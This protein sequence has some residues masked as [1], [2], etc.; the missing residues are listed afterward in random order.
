[1]KLSRFSFH[2]D[3][4][5]YQLVTLVNELL[6]ASVEHKPERHRRLF[7]THL[8]PRGIKELAAPRQQRI[9]LAVVRLLDSLEV[10]G[11]RERLA[12]LRALRDELLLGSSAHMR[13][14]TARVLIAIMKRLVRERGNLPAQLLLAHDFFRAVSGQPRVIRRELCRH[15]LLE[16]P[17]QWSQIA[18]DH[19]VHDANTKGRKAPTHLIMD[20]CVKG[21]RELM[22]VYYNYMR[23]DAVAE[24]TEAAEIMGIEVRAGVE[25]S[26]RF[27]GKYVQLIWFPHGF[28]GHR[29]L[30]DFLGQ[31]RVEAFFEEGK[32]VAALSRRHVLALLASFNQNHLSSLNSKYSLELAPLDEEEFLAFVGIGQPSVVHLA[33]FIHHLVLPR[34]PKK[35]RE[36][37]KRLASA[38]EQK[39]ARIRIA[40]ELLNDLIPERITEEYLRPIDNVDVP[41][42]M[43]PVPGEPLP[44]LLSL[45]L[46]EIVER[47]NSIRSGY[48]LV[49]NP[50]NLSAADVLEL[51]Y[52]AEG[53]ITGLEIFN[54]KDYVQGTNSHIPTIARLRH[55]INAGGAIACKRLV[56]A[57]LRDVSE[58][59]DPDKG[60]RCEKLQRILHDLPRLLSF[61]D[62]NPIRARM[63]SDSTGRARSLFG[64]GLAVEKTLPGA[65]R[66]EIKRRPGLRETIPVRM[67]AVLQRTWFPRRGHTESQV[68]FY[69]ALRRLPLLRT[70]GYEPQSQYVHLENQTRYVE[71]G[72]IVTLGGV[73]VEAD[74]NLHLHAKDEPDSAVTAGTRHL[75]V[76]WR[77]ALK[78][79][80]G[81]V[82]AF[83]T[84]YLTQS[85]WVLAY[86]GAFIWF[87]VT[88]LRNVVQSVVGGGGLLR[89]Q[90][91]KWNDLVR[92]ERVC[93]DLLF[94]GFSVPLLD[95]LVK[96]VILDHGFGVTTMTA[97]VVLYSIMGLANGIYL[98]SHNTFRGLPRAAAVGNLFRSVISIPI[99]LG[100]N[101][102][103]GRIMLA[104]G[105]SVVEAQGMLQLWAAVIG[106]VASDTVAGFIE[107]LADRRVLL[108]TRGQ[109]YQT[110]LSQLLAIHGRLETLFPEENALEMLQDPKSFQRALSEK[111]PALERQL[112]ISV[113]DLMTFW[114]M[115]PRSRQVF[116][117]QLSRMSAEER[118]IVLRTQRLLLDRHHVSALFLDDLVGDNFAK[119]LAFYLSRSASYLKDMDRLLSDSSTA[120][121]V[122]ALQRTP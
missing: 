116:R 11:A 68:R 56:E 118:L 5:D 103:V 96:T 27:R 67:E 91:L 107:G 53:A 61:H 4:Q 63:G 41:G 90:R 75:S 47:L 44:H 121:S 89:A 31:S 32:Q 43:D 58:G 69:R 95:W 19:H 100:I 26:A 36:L 59:K 8:H 21:V 108:Q 101:D 15:H 49:L 28:S 80:I 86:L 99:A 106:K 79:F 6:E 1:M 39:Q 42:P 94:T 37:R 20:A 97:P 7:N 98:F 65:A 102:L 50:S 13:V 87:S 66:R 88:G 23:A 9:A 85:W 81:F 17:E 30:V 62:H 2:L 77:N 60:E 78:V 76:F 55:A 72:N 24:L 16:M 48:R 110:K 29:G 119:P 93:D 83:L 22:V 122:L 82:P 64:M 104:G 73:G 52:D 34:L 120:D 114:M 112:V 105:M 14:N 92:W 74:N 54:L 35:L 33:E 46:R 10:G 12:A 111:D 84:F 18:F 57:V 38:G 25:V 113:L 109:D 115:Q 51:I 71:A 117:R 3:R 40:F 70:F 45:S